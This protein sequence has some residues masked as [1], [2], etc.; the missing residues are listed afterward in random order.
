M[1]CDVAGFPD[2][3]TCPG[4]VRHIRSGGIAVGQQRPKTVLSQ[5]RRGIRFFG[6]NLAWISG[7][8]FHLVGYGANYSTSSAAKASASTLENG[9]YT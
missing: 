3:L 8:I 6:F 7:G 1:Q 9:Y 4:A 2:I 5:S